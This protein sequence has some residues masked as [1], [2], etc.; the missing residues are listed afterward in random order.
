MDKDIREVF[1]LRIKLAETGANVAAIACGRMLRDRDWA[2]LAELAAE[3]AKNVANA[4]AMRRQL[5]EDS[6]A[7]A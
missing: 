1:E 3:T 4:D 6:H 2:A 7:E 5:E